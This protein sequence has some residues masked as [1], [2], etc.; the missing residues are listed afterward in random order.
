M[1]MLRFLLSGLF[2]GLIIQS[3]AQNLL[4]EEDFDYPAN[5]LLRDHNWTPHSAAG[6]NPLAVG[7]M[8]LSF[9]NT[10]YVG[11]NIGGAALVDNTG[12]DENKAFVA[13]VD[14]G[15]V[16]AAFLMKPGAVVTSAGTG[17]FFHL[18]TY[19]NPANPDPSSISTAFRARTFI[20]QGS[21]PSTFRVGL[22]FN[23][24]A[25]PTNVGV[26]VSNDLDTSETYLLIVKYTFVPGDDNDEVSLYVF[27]DGDDISVEPATPTL[28]PYGGTAAD[29]SVLQG[30]ALR[31]YNA[32]Q[33]IIVDGIRVRTDWDF[34]IDN[35]SVQ[36]HE[37]K[38]HRT[39]YPN[40]L[41]GNILN[42]DTGKNTPAECVM[43]DMHGKVILSETIYQNQLNLPN[44]QTGL[45]M[46]QIRQEG[47][48]TNHKVVVQ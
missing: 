46:L 39:V 15:S 28:G 35:F 47:I 36:T 5:S 1:S 34:E 21:D 38:F 45:Y 13:D 6:T 31:Q 11:G 32:E 37:S 24:A 26:D 41:S 10:P 48:V 3:Q 14:S 4:L 44:L 2:I 30:V 9:I 43:T 20:T 18:V 12:S 40:P 42:M 27:A 16:Y 25:A 17:F 8:N 23:A 7:S 29:A 22:T 33:N 19:S